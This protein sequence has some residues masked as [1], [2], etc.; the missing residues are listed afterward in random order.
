MFV[1]YILFSKKLSKFYIGMTSNFDVRLVFH[2]N[3]EQKRK[4][5]YNADDWVL[6]FKMDCITKKQALNIERHI[7]SMK[8]K[9]YIENLVK[10]PNIGQKLFEKYLDC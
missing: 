8:S 1:V 9:I 7:K 4:F 3:D 2:L 10:Y 5:T 6:F